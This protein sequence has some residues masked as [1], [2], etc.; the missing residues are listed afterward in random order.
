MP[1]PGAGAHVTRPPSAR[2]RSVIPGMPR[3]DP[4]TPSAASTPSAGPAPE[5]TPAATPVGTPAPSSVTSTCS[6]R[7]RTCAR[8]STTV[9]SQCRTAFVTAS[10][11]T[12]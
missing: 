4:S 12:R 3:P 6:R 9:P 2:A 11:T 8:T 10:W 5:A 7:P 1:P